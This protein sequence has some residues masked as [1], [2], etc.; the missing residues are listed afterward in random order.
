VTPQRV[1][2]MEQDRRRRAV[3]GAAV[4][5]ALAWIVL[6]AVYY[7][8]PIGSRY[9]GDAIARAAVGAVLFVLVLLRQIRKVLKSDVPGVR[10]VEALGV[11]IPLFLVVFATTYL[12]MAVASQSTFSQP[13]NHTKALYFTITVFT[14][15]GFG[16]ITPKTDTARLVVSI[17][18]L[19]DLVVLGAVVQLLV[20]ATKASLARDPH[21]SSTQ[22]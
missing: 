7:L 19:L 8:L 21:R 6:A 14:T 22:R 18:M 16:D 4:S 10:A 12:S 15:V 20:K 2:E 17:Q 3:L 13:L 11:V 1:S 5:I 9:K